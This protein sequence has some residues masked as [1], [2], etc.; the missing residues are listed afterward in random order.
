FREALRRFAVLEASSEA[1]VSEVAAIVRRALRATVDLDMI[2]GRLEG[3]AIVLAHYRDPSA[4]AREHGAMVLIDR[5]FSITKDP[6]APDYPSFNIS[7]D[8]WK[9]PKAADARSLARGYIASFLD[10]IANDQRDVPS[11]VSSP[12]ELASFLTRMC[13]AEYHF[14]AR[15]PWPPEALELIE[16]VIGTL[17]REQQR[18]VLLLRYGL[19]DGQ[20]RTLRRVGAELGG[21]SPERIRQVEAKAL[22]LLRHPSRAKFLELLAA[23][24]G[25]FTGE[26]ARSSLA[27]L[28]H[29]QADVDVAVARAA[30][31]IQGSPSSRD[32]LHNPTLVAARRQ[33]CQRVPVD[34]PELL[35][36]LRLWVF[37]VWDWST[38]AQSALQYVLISRLG[39][40]NPRIGDIVQLRR[41]DL[42]MHRGFGWKSLREV[43]EFLEAI[44]LRLG[45]QF[46]D[47]LQGS[48]AL[49]K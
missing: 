30:R 7:T 43:E 47:Q 19:R 2:T 5:I 35:S 15:L 39:I 42:L 44:G 31:T 37:E 38:R 48:L 25:T 10:A 24:F 33:L 9:R 13:V 18:E 40:D 3:A 12:E 16:A 14:S 28:K 22:R 20:L 4:D 21:K 26:L 46:S 29:S 6:R 32:T 27:R 41:E 17:L 49:P 8:L 11:D 23:T 45:L 36:V 34:S 1:N